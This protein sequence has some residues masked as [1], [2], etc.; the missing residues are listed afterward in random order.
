MNMHKD[1]LHL[2]KANQFENVIH[3]LWWRMKVGRLQLLDHILYILQGL[4]TGHLKGGTGYQST[5]LKKST[6]SLKFILSF[7]FTPAI[8]I[9]AKE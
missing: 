5:L 3:F 4:M 7:D 8:F 9:I 1:D 2:I 6:N